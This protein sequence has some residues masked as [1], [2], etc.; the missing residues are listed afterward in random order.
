MSGV[1]EELLKERVW[2]VVLP[3]PRV[4]VR[5]A[6]VVV[7]ERVMVWSVPVRL[8]VVEVAFKVPAL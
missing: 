5:V 2:L 6:K 1:V 3:T 8:R 7:A 4:L